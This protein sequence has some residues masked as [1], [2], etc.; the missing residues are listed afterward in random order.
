MCGSMQATCSQ[1]QGYKFSEPLT[2]KRAEHEKTRYGSKGPDRVLFN[3][4]K[5]GR[6][7]RGLVHLFYRK[8]LKERWE[9]E[10]KRIQEA[11]ASLLKAKA[12]YLQRTQVWLLRP[13]V[14]FPPK[15]PATFDQEYDRCRETLRAAESEG[16][17]EKF[18]KKKRS[19]EEA[20]Q[21]LAESE[22]LYKQ[23]VAEANER[24]HH[25]LAAK[26]EILKQV[27]PSR[28]NVSRCCTV[29]RFDFRC[30]FASLTFSAI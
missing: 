27:G 25:L 23:C 16:G 14:L 21:K 7:K 8:A 11:V 29:T 20:L 19:E 18:D 13:F 17:S 5:D 2:L 15:P 10:R 1:I 4:M 9:K 28:R 3:E 26:A 22:L 30:R 6:G 12:I 24:Q